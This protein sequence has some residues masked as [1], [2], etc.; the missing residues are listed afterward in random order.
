MNDICNVSN[1]F[2][3][4][5]FAD[6]TSIFTSNKDIAKPYSDTNRELNK[7]YTWLCVNKLTNII[8][9]TNDS[10]FSNIHEN[11]VTSIGIN[12]INLQSLLN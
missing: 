2:T 1:I 8:E 12:N 3:F 4:V 6:D 10:V 9:K 7:S 11:F 5:L